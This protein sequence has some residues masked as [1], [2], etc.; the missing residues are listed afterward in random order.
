MSTKGDTGV[1]SPRNKT[2]PGSSSDQTHKRNQLST[3]RKKSGS[4]NAK[5]ADESTRE[6][7]KSSRNEPSTAPPSGTGICWERKK[8]GSCK[9]GDH[10]AYKTVMEASNVLAL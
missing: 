9:H 6:D 4:T 3:A 7:N 2:V 10:C 8:K 5:K 1:P